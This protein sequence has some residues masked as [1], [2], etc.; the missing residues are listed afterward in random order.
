[1]LT[2]K[3]DNGDKLQQKAKK[4]LKLKK[5]ADKNAAIFTEAF[6]DL[7]K[8]TNLKAVMALINDEFKFKNN[9]SK[10]RDG[11]EIALSKSYGIRGGKFVQ[12]YQSTRNVERDEDFDSD[13]TTTSKSPAQ[14]QEKAKATRVSA[15]IQDIMKYTLDIETVYNTWVQ[16]LI[17]VG[18][19]LASNITDAD[20][21]DSDD[22]GDISFDDEEDNIES[23]EDFDNEENEE[24][25]EEN[26]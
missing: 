16:Q 1:M 7:L 8:D 15:M 17:D 13:V 24:A 5:Y 18:N 25:L 10:G 14:V 20:L 19:E 11:K 23:E 4:I 12:Y 6:E 2:F 22:L 3:L 26:I 21:E 9:F